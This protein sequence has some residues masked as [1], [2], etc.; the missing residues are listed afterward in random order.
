VRCP[1]V[2]GKSALRFTGS[3]VEGSQTI[4]R[5]A[6]SLDGCAIVCGYNTNF[7]GPE[8]TPGFIRYST[9]T[10]KPTTVLGLYHM[11][12]QGINGGRFTSLPG[13]AGL[14]AAAW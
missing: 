7:A 12:G 3:G 14:A 1:P 13:T 8:T 4:S 11:N 2:P 9:T 10:G 6:N 5:A